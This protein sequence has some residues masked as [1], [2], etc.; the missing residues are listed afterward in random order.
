MKILEGVAIVGL[1]SEMVLALV[2]ANRIYTDHGETLV[3]TSALDGEHMRASLHYV[4]AAADVRYPILAH[5][6][7]IRELREA[8]GTNYDVVKEHDH[9]HIE[10]QP[11]VGA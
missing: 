11:K 3:V 6:T 1:R 9:I 8:L 5:K 10:F 4:G 7:L 2:I